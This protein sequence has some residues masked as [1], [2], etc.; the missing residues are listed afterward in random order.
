[1]AVKQEVSE[2]ISPPPTTPGKTVENETD[3]YSYITYGGTCAIF[4]DNRFTIYAKSNTSENNK[5]PSIETWLITP[6]SLTSLETITSRELTK[7]NPNSTTC[8]RFNFNGHGIIVIEQIIS[9]GPNGEDT[10][11][12]QPYLIN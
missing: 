2:L 8:H 10:E 4:E 12:S 5:S 7:Y 9:L 6:G 1:M 3:A 11:L